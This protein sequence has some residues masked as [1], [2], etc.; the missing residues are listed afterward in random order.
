MIFSFFRKNNT[1]NAQNT[2][3]NPV[4]YSAVASS[5]VG[6][7]RENNEDKVLFIKPY[8]KDV[9]QQKGMLGIVADGMGGH[10]CGE[11]ASQ[12]AVDVI[13]KQY[14]QSKLEILEALEMSFISA[15]QKIFK[16]A[17][18]NENQKG[19]GTT[20]TAVVLHQRDLYL[21]HAGDSRAYLVN[22]NSVKKLSTDHTYVQFLLDNGVINE[23]QMSNHPE[24]NVITKSMGTQKTLIPDILKFE[25]ILHEDDLIFLCSDGLYE[26]I[27]EP[28]IQE[29]VLNN[30]IFDA[31]EQMIQVAKTR[32]GHDNISVLI[33]KQSAPENENLLSVTQEMK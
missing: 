25:N 20:C 10:N 16:K 27:K 1:H 19:M 14:Y 9:L 5:D 23:S 12:I 31:A 29:Y 13:S 26:Y 22:K 15:N 30:S 6:S 17:A 24:R 28:E 2:N 33:I 21:A 18:K 7:V 11:I 3:C 32:G 8:D 4:S